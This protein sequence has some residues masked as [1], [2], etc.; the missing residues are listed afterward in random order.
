MEF[1]YLLGDA[2]IQ[3]LSE[4]K[5]K[6]FHH[7]IIDENFLAALVEDFDQKFYVSGPPRMV[8]AVTG[9]LLKLGV[10]ERSVI[11]EMGSTIGGA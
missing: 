3:I 5:V 1:D 4:Q 9:D 7:G 8:S 10:N 2:L 11:L 6:G